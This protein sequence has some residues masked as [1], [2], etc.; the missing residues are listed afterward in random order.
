MRKFCLWLLLFSCSALCAADVR[1]EFDA[2]D[3]GNIVIPA[4]IE[5]SAGG[6]RM[7]NGKEGIVIPGSEKF[8]FAESGLTVMA[9]LCMEKCGMNSSGT[10][11]GG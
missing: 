7:H 5:R 10:Y 2:A 3:P 1:Y 9:T 6:F 4:G 11:A 8:R